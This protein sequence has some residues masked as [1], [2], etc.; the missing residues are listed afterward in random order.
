MATAAPIRSTPGAYIEWP[1]SEASPPRLRTDIAG[2]VERGPLHA[3]VAVEGWSGFRSVFGGHI[4]QGF[5][6][7]SV[8]SFFANGGARAWIV[9]AADPARVA[10]GS[11]GTALAGI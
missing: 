5:L 10:T 3:P 2:F 1:Q 11:T 6:A 8:E 7:P 9:R 4:R